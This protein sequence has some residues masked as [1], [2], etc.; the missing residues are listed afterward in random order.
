MQRLINGE[1]KKN[2]DL[3][4]TGT[5][6][7][8]AALSEKPESKASFANAQ[9]TSILQAQR[10]FGTALAEQIEVLP[11]GLLTNP[12]LLVDG[13]PHPIG[14]V[15]MVGLR[16]AARLGALKEADAREIPKDTPQ[17]Q[18]QRGQLFTQH[19]AAQ[20][21]T[22]LMPPGGQFE[23]AFQA[24]EDFV[25]QDGYI[26]AVKEWASGQV[27]TFVDEAANRQGLDVTIAEYAD[28]VDSLLKAGATARARQLANSELTTI[29]YKNDGLAR[30]DAILSSIDPA[31]VSAEDRKLLSKA[32]RDKIALSN[33][34]PSFSIV[35]TKK[36]SGNNANIEKQ[37]LS[38]KFQDP[39]LERIRKAVAK[40]WSTVAP[41][42]DRLYRLQD[43]ST[44]GFFT[45]EGN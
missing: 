16:E 25:T 38:Y 27:R 31:K 15:D 35:D 40:E 32:V 33:L 43:Q 39:N 41:T 23:T 6:Q 24:Y 14:Q 28:D 30:M 10:A 1:R 37:I 9:R 22:R 26:P 44:S 45:E 5:A 2:G 7:L 21:N 42:L 13:Q 20:L 17:G 36:L 3:P 11:K 12:R 4:L 34:G 19:L 29:T 8:L 18:V